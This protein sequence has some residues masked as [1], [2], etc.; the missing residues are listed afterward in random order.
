MLTG[1]K[2]LWL[3]DRENLPERYMTT[4]WKLRNDDLKTCRAWAIKENVRHL[5]SYHSR[6]WA[7][8]YWKKWYFWARH[9]RL[10]PMTKAAKT[11][12]NPITES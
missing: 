4:F 1:T 11:L 12:E 8:K 7:E 5:W 9:S 6:V 3:Y 10:E 2:Y